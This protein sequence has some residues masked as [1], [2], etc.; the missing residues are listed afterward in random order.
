MANKKNSEGYE[1]I[2]VRDVTG[3]A[4]GQGGLLSTAIRTGLC[5]TGQLSR[6][7]NAEMAL[8]VRRNTQGRANSKCKGTDV[9]MSSKNGQ[10]WPQ[11]ARTTLSVEGGRMPVR[12]SEEGAG[13]TGGAFCPQCKGLS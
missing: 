12:K 2:K 13:E 11:G 3:M 10:P 8:A 4:Q 1:D 5:E 9:Q 7:P 6:N